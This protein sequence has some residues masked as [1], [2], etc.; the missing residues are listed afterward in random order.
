MQKCRLLCISRTLPF[1]SG[2]PLK[3]HTRRSCMVYLS[4][5]FFAL[6][7]LS[8]VVRESFLL[9]WSRCSLPPSLPCV[10]SSRE[11][12]KSRLCIMKLRGET[13][14]GGQ[15]LM[16]RITLHG[17]NAR[18]VYGLSLTS[19]LRSRTNVCRWPGG[20]HLLDNRWRSPA[21]KSRSW[22]EASPTP[23]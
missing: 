14:D 9:L 3:L 18:C 22:I 21:P 10:Q 4:P 23:M 5:L 16:T 7:R 13:T 2:R 20:V 15:S 11:A 6:L 8:Q 17:D 1:R 12:N 19:Q